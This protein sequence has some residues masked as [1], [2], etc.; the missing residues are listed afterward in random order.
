MS[1]S[2]DLKASGVLEFLKIF[3]RERYLQCCTG[4]KKVLWTNL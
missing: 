1:S 4:K 3:S 2:L